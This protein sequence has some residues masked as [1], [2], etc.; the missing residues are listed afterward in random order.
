[1]ADHAHRRTSAPTQKRQRKRLA[2]LARAGGRPRQGRNAVQRKHTRGTNAWNARTQRNGDNCNRCIKNARRT[3]QIRER[4][5]SCSLQR[6]QTWPST[7]NRL[8]QCKA[9]GDGIPGPNE[10]KSGMNR[11][12]EVKLRQI[13][14]AANRA[15]LM[16]SETSQWDAL[17]SKTGHTDRT[18]VGSKSFGRDQ[19]DRK[20][21]AHRRRCSRQR[22][23]PCR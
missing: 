6:A 14:N 3:G 12:L 23:R 5:A 15:K 7:R 20:T 1:M 13:H 21:K 10:P 2:R 17:Q 9:A 19:T 4:P 22:S 8:L 11:F 16:R 18:P